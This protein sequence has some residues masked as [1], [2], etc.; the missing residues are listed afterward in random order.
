MLRCFS[1]YSGWDNC[2][3]LAEDEAEA[4]KIAKYF[5][6]KKPICLG[7]YPAQHAYDGK[8]IPV[9]KKPITWA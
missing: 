2:F 9:L 5:G 3:V 6:Y 4:L 8:G 1:I 7:A